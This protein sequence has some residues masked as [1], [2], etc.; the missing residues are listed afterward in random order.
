[1]IGIELVS[2]RGAKTPAA[3]PAAAVKRRCRERG[4]LIGVGGFFGNVVRIQP[5]LVIGED[6][7][8][9]A[10]TIIEESIAEQIS[11][12]ASPSLATVAATSSG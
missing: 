7:L 5:P 4:V 12:A 6:E 11:P 8:D 1:M 2:D 10:V 3:Q 9:R